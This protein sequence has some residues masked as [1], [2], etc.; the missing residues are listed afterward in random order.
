MITHNM[1]NEN[2]S[3]CKYS[4]RRS[5][6]TIRLKW[7]SAPTLYIVKQTRKKEMSCDKTCYYVYCTHC[8]YLAGVVENVFKI[9]SEESG[10]IL[11]EAVKEFEVRSEGLH[12]TMIA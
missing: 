4:K 5:F 6:G 10:A 3:L 1:S 9:G 12:S 11:Y 8:V 7:K 2:K